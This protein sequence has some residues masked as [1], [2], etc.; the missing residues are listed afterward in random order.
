MVAKEKQVQIDRLSE[1]LSVRIAYTEAGISWARVNF[2]IC[3][4]ANG[5]SIEDSITVPMSLSYS[6]NSEAINEAQQAACEIF[7]HKLTVATQNAQ[8]LLDAIVERNRRE[9]K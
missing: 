2:E 9:G 6:Y 5:N 3:D 1:E 7:V 4:C 8:K